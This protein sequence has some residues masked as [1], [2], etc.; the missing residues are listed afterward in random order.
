MGTTETSVPVIRPTLPPMEDVADAVK[1][2][3]DSGL[4]TVAENVRLFEKEVE[5]FTGA[6]HAVAVSSCTSGLILAFAALDLPE[7]AE[8]V[9]PS[10]T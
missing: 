2:S 10:F 8:V 3:Y 7:G 6:K 1:R 5:S 4:V 9:V